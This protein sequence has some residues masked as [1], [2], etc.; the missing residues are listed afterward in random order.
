M[1]DGYNGLIS[2]MDLSLRRGEVT[3]SPGIWYRTYSSGN[4]TTLHDL[5]KETYPFLDPLSQENQRI[6][7]CSMHYKRLASCPVP[8]PVDPGDTLNDIVPLTMNR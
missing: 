1:S 8:Y 5:L 2:N 7:A 3:D 4:G 6:L